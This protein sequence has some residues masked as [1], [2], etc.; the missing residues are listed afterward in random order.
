MLGSSTQLQ[1]LRWRVRLRQGRPSI[2]R[3]YPLTRAKYE[4]PVRPQ[5]LG[6]ANVYDS[7]GAANFPCAAPEKEDVPD[8]LHSPNQRY[9]DWYNREMRYPEQ[10]RCLGAEWLPASW[11]GRAAQRWASAT[12]NSGRRP[13]SPVRCRV[14]GRRFRCRQR[15]R[16]SPLS[17]SARATDSR[18][19]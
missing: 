19:G 7:A 12:V 3:W 17:R 6:R 5:G 4:G 2:I 13:R 11:R 14:A 18:A 16:C 8:L 9:V 15:G 10:A 1:L